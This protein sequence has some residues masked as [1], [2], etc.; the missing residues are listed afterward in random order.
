MEERRRGKNSLPAAVA[1]VRL[2]VGSTGQTVAIGVGHNRALISG[3]TAMMRVIRAISAARPGSRSS[4]VQSLGIDVEYAEALEQHLGSSDPAA[5]PGTPLGPACRCCAEAR[6]TNRVRHK[7]G[8]LQVLF[9]RHENLFIEFHD[10]SVEFITNQIFQWRT[11]SGVSS[12][13]G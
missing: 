7:E 5:T 1:R 4:N 12:R 2:F 8:F 11:L 3:R 6:G 9:S 13:S 10:V